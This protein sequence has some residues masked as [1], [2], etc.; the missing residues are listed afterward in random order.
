MASNGDLPIV[1][2]IV[3]PFFLKYCLFYKPGLSIFF[4]FFLFFFIDIHIFE[5]LPTYFSRGQNGDIILI[6]HASLFFNLF[7][8]V[9][10][11]KIFTG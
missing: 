9:F 3:K 4:L 11:L 1:K 5:N 2:A 7:W 10:L 8:I 6:N